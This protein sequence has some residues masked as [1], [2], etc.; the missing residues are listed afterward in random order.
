MGNSKSKS[1]GYGGQ[2]MK[3]RPEPAPYLGIPI[4]YHFVNID[5][6]IQ[7]N[8]CFA[9]I[10]PGVNMN[11]LDVNSYIPMLNQLYQQGY[12]MLSFLSKPGTIQTHGFASF[13]ATSTIRYQAVLRP[14][15]DVSERGQY[16]IRT[17]K[18]ILES[19]SFFTGSGL[20]LAHDM[21]SV[22][23]T[24]H[25]YQTI[26]NMTKTGAR[27]VC[28]EI[29]GFSPFSMAPGMGMMGHQGIQNNKQMRQMM[30]FGYNPQISMYTRI[31][32]FIK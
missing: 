24:D 25:I 1:V 5:A 8:A 30:M 10:R 16:E 19:R 6:S 20:M 29:T 22:S 7:F 11:T 23:N 21:S 13:D 3:P 27:F 18:S 12:R 26:A 14:L 32:D 9:R 17:E 2:V 15:T 4:S 28:L 31:T